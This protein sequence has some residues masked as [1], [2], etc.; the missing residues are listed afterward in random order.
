MANTKE[1]LAKIFFDHE[2]IWSLGCGSV[3]NL[4][5]VIGGQVVGTLNASMPSITTRPSGWRWLGDFACLQRPP[6][7]QCGIGPAQHEYDGQSSKLP[8]STAFAARLRYAS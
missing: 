2:L 8:S 6:G 7:S 5:I 4:P 1:D 3:I